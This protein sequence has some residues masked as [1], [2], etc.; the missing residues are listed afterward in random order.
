VILEVLTEI[1]SF[2]PENF[3]LKGRRNMYIK[4]LSFMLLLLLFII[5]LL[6]TIFFSSTGEAGTEEVKLT[7]VH[8]NDLHSMIMPFSEEDEEKVGGFARIAALLKR[9]RNENEN[10][11]FLDA[12]DLLAGS[13][14]IYQVN[15]SLPLWGY[16]GLLEVELMNQMGLD[17]MVLGNHEFDFGVRWLERLLEE[18][19]FKVLSANSFYRFKPDVEGRNGEAIVD[20]Y[21]FFVFNGVE[22]A[23]IGLTTPIYIKSSQVLVKFP[24]P[25]EIPEILSKEL[26]HLKEN[27]DL[28][29]VLSHLGIE[30]DRKLVRE[31]DGIDLI[32]GGHSHTET[33]EPMREGKTLIVQAGEYGKKLGKMDIVM[34]DGKIVSYDYRLIPVDE[35][36]EPDKRVQ[37]LIQNKEVIGEIFGNSLVSS[38]QEQSTLGRFTADAMCWFTGADVALLNS[39]L[40]K[41]ELKKGIIRAD[42]FFKVFWPYRVRRL[43]PEK[44][45]TEKQLIEM[46]KK[47]REERSLPLGSISGKSDGLESV[48]LLELIGEELLEVINRSNEQV[49][50]DNYLQISGI[51]LESREI[52]YN[53]IPGKKYKVAVN[54]SLA[55]GKG[56]YEQLWKPEDFKVLNKEV[57]EVVLEYFEHFRSLFIKSSGMLDFQI[58]NYSKNL[59]F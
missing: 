26:P 12:G 27:A 14:R 40:V 25:A 24:F 44:D 11:L 56:G 3:M 1:G 58:S 37:Q 9:I 53:L 18:A 31:V 35:K 43:G 36:I 39:G 55:L 59:F 45:L 52:Y 41:G 8:T 33:P 20:P 23:V 42:D 17:A 4:K 54:L 6:I 49:G 22:V 13:E 15:Y 16:R 48:V 29:V 21:A 2:E 46:V 28:I 34:E 19:K 57:F 10:V 5:L 32:V 50:T 38:C 51:D 47:Q 30:N 7:I